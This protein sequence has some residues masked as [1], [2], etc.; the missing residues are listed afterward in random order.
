MTDM[1]LR[2]ESAGLMRQL[3]H[4]VNAPSVALLDLKQRWTAYI[5]RTSSPSALH[6]VCISLLHRVL[7]AWSVTESLQVTMMHIFTGA[8]VMLRCCTARHKALCY[9]TSIHAHVSLD[10]NVC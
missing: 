9:T 6:Q 7:L 1:L 2:G 3:S 4:N 5:A 8:G 10:V